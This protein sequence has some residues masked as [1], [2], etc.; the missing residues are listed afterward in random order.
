MGE[1]WEEHGDQVDPTGLLTRLE[2]YEELPRQLVRTAGVDVQKDR[3]ECTVVDWGVGEEAWTLEHRILP[4][5]TAQPAVWQ[6][7]DDEL[8]H[9]GPQAVA[10]DSGYNTSMVYAYV[11][12][13]RWALAV[14][15]RAGPGVP[16]VE[17]EKTRRMRLRRQRK[18]GIMVHLVGD[19]QAKALIYSRLKITAPGPAYIHFPNDASFDDEYFAQLTAEKLVTKMRGTRPYAEWQQIRPRNEALDCWK[20]ALAALR[21]S[22]IDLRMRAAIEAGKEAAPTGPAI[23]RLGRVGRSG[24]F[25]H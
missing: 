13:R 18:K 8:Q 9:W 6:M 10:I 24:M 5:D 16:L 12:K 20:Y 17:D 22:G 2:D 1:C 11:E 3:L 25:N 19:D 21:L 23:R 7:L 14:K 4:G 15:G